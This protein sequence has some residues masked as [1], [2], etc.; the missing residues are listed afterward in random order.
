MSLYYLKH[1]KQL[2]DFVGLGF[3]QASNVKFRELYIL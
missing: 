2:D 1:H 3:T